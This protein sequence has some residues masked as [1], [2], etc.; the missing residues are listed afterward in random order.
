MD[1]SEI[2]NSL[3]APDNKVRNDIE[4]LKQKGELYEPE[5]DHIKAT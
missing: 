4:K 1:R 5:T 2:K 3:D